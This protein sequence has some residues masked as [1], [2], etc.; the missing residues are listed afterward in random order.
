MVIGQIS[1]IN[2]IGQQLIARYPPPV[3][4]STVGRVPANTGP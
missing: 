2:Q 4:G 3:P 1:G